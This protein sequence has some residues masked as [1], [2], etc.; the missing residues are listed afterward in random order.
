MTMTAT[1]AVQEEQSKATAARAVRFA[2]LEGVKEELRGRGWFNEPGAYV[3]VD[4]QFGS[5]GKG[6][7]AGVLGETGLGR[8]THVTS[9]AGPNSGH[10]AYI[11]DFPVMTRQIP[12]AS[13]VHAHR[14]H[15]VQ[16]YLN[17]GAIL[18]LDVLHQ[19]AGDERIPPALLTIHPAA[20]V[21]REEDK[22]C[23]ADPGSGAAKIASTGKGVGAAL[24][25][26]IRR[27][28]NVAEFYKDDLPGECRA[29]SWDWGRHRVFVETA[30]GFSLGINSEFYPYVTSRECTVM[31]AI[32]DARIPCQMVKKVAA[33]YRTFPIRVGNTANGHSGKG[34][35]DQQEIDWKDLGVE[36]ELTSVTKRVRRVFTWSRVQFKESVLANRPDL[37]FLNFLQYLDPSRQ[38]IFI[39]QVLDDYKEM[40]G[41]WP[42]VLLLGHGPRP[43]D[44]EIW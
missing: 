8:I 7:L 43:E 23:E 9:N 39:K 31:Q 29:L 14:R 34:Y 37:V 40:I 13:V 10:T 5:T 2:R 21:I 20:T 11:D 42:E 16:T 36:P 30:Q 44:V 22:E 12:I 6:L 17:G 18:D 24:A 15:P 4:G 38:P 3:L 33:C 26:K 19:E 28:C 41:R 35:P 27:E 32:A 25:G 1:E